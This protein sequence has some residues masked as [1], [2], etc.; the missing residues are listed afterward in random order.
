MESLEDIKA[1]ALPMFENA[2]VAMGKGAMD[3]L[4]KVNAYSVL[5]TINGISH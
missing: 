4:E 5:K 2:R 3:N 1:N